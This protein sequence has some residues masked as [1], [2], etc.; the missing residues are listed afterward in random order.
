MGPS[1]H[2]AKASSA[3]GPSCVKAHRG[4]FGMGHRYCQ[5]YAR[6]QQGLV[7]LPEDGVSWVNLSEAVKPSDGKV[8][9][10]PV[11]LENC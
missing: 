10:S 7:D 6:M 9:F 11:L 1:N 5:G 8:Q 3:M 4:Y 2:S